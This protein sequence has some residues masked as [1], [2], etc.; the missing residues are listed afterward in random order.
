[1]CILNILQKCKQMKKTK[2]KQSSHTT[3]IAHHFIDSHLKPE[4]FKR[5][6]LCRERKWLLLFSPFDTFLREHPRVCEYHGTT[7]KSLV[8]LGPGPRVAVRVRASARA[9]AACPRHPLHNSN[10][11]SSVSCCSLDNT[12]LSGGSVFWLLHTQLFLLLRVFECL[13]HPFV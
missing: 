7:L 2:T 12:L 3:D 1:M 10:T 8:P 13:L 4:P 11:H 9:P 6:F 5:D